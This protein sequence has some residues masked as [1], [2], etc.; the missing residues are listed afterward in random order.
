MRRGIFALLACAA[1]LATGAAGASAQMY[2]DAQD[3]C[4]ADATW[5]V[6]IGEDGT[7]HADLTFAGV[8]DLCRRAIGTIDDPDNWSFHTEHT[9]Q[10]GSVR[11]EL[12]GQGDATN[13]AGHLVLP[14]TGA[15]GA[16]VIAGGQ[17][18]NAVI[19]RAGTRM[20]TVHRATGTCGAGCFTTSMAWTRRGI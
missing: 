17:T 3:V 16:I 9:D 19:G 1:A 5:Q 10:G 2:S 11:Y 13:F 12:T 20:V 7:G 14:E 18:L 15:Q 4:Y 8:P 6:T